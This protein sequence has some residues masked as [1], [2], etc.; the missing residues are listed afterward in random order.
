[1]SQKRVVVTGLGAV[2]PIGNDVP[3]FWQ[4][5]KDGKSGGG[6]ITK[7]DPTEFKTRIAAELKDFNA[8]QHFDPK[9]VKKLDNFARYGVVAAREC[10]ADSGLDLDKTDPFQIGVIVGS[11][12]GGVQTIE[13]QVITMLEKGIRR[14]SPFLVPKMIPNMAA[15]MIS[16]YLKVKGPN[17]AIATACATGTHAIGDSYKIIQRGDAV[18]MFAG[19]AEAIITRLSVAG[20]SNMQA[21]T[22]HNDEPTRASRPFDATRDGFLMGEGAGVLLLE[23]LE[24]AKARGAKIYCEVV[25]YGLSGDAH[26]MTAPGPCG[27]GGA[28]AMNMCIKDAGIPP[29]AVQY[30]NAHGT[31]TP[32]NDKLETQAIKTVFGDHAYKLAVSSN[33][34]MIGH[35]IGAAGG[36]EAIATALTI[37]EGI[38]PPTINYVTPDPECDLDYVPNKARAAQVEY[39][40][41]NSLGFGGHNCTICL[42]RY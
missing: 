30:V 37:K 17:S 22:E 33:K 15:G 26:H 14:V 29:T 13:E 35:L 21:L 25:G 38:I 28:R 39:A 32:L 1:M 19:G 8:D 40:I 2:T 11:G 42:K 16:I 9:E 5:L 34:S 24:H 12:M 20:F 4:G 3:T 18:A 36:V 7:F 31:S 10:M 41:S 23:E 27:E 6:V